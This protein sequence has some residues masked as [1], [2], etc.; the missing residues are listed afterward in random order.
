VENIVA[1][2][3]SVAAGVTVAVLAKPVWLLFSGLARMLSTDFPR[4]SGTWTARFTEPTKSGSSE[5][6]SETIT[7]H[8]LGRLVWG[9]GSVTDERNRKFKYKGSILRHTLNGTYCRQKSRSPAGTGT[10]Q[11]RVAG[12]DDSMSGWCIWYDRDTDKIEA[13]SYEWRKCNS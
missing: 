2:L 5:D 13:S 1:Y 7:I 9:E 11:L 12:S 4:L 8:Q 10:F 6:I 3:I